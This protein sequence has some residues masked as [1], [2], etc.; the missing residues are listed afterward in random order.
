MNSLNQKQIK[1][2][3]WAILAAATGTAATMAATLGISSFALASELVFACSAEGVLVEVS[4]LNN[5]TLRYEAYNIPTTHQR[6]D[7]AINGGTVGSNAQRDTLYRFRN[8]NYL[9][10]AVDNNAYG[11]VLIY[12]NNKLIGKKYCG[13]V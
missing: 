4:R 1:S 12:K 11:E 13:D 10:V 7:L 5:G 3:L 8:G 6:P 9:Y 2:L